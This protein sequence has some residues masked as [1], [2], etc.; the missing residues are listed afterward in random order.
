MNSLALVTEQNCSYNNDANY[1]NSRTVIV[2]FHYA[3]A[4]PSCAVLACQRF[5]VIRSEA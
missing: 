5:K 3:N 2:D 1:E 4:D